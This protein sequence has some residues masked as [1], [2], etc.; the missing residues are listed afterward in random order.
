LVAFVDRDPPVE[1]RLELAVLGE[2]GVRGDL[3][4]AEELATGGEV[5]MEAEAVAGGEA[6]DDGTNDGTD[7][8]ICGVTTVPGEA[9][10][11][12]LEACS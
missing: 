8:G 9:E 5:W 10:L 6:I 4:S 3:S 1:T 7:D 11:D 12:P 2:E